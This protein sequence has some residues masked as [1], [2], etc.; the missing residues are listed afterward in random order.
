MAWIDLLFLRMARLGAFS[1]ASGVYLARISRRLCRFAASAFS[2]C[3]SPSMSLFWLILLPFL[4]SLV[5]ALMPTKA[6]TP[7]ASWAAA[8]AA[9]GLA[10]VAWRYPQ[11]RDGQALREQAANYQDRKSV[12]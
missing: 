4:G 9:C 6:R 7:A 11:L 12:V 8:V 1:R 3:P 5:A 2:A 10:A